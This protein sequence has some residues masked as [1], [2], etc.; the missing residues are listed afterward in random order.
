MNSSQFDVR[1]L[2][3]D[4]VNLDEPLTATKEEVENLI[5]SLKNRLK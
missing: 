1:R 4:K 5:K 3:L 2:D